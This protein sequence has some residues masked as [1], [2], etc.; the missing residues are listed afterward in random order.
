MEMPKTQAANP[1]PLMGANLGA[2]APDVVVPTYDRNALRPGI[3][4]IGV[5][6]FHRAHQALYV[7]KLLSQ[8]EAQNRWHP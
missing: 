2:I 8:G 4:H 6:A 7:D 3:V 5:G 1:L